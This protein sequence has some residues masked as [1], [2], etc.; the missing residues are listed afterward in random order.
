MVSELTGKIIF[1]IILAVLG[2]GISGKNYEA[3]MYKKPS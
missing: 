1:F 2:K 3:A